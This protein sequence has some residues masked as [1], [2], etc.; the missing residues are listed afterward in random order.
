VYSSIN[1][2][3]VREPRMVR[4]AEHVVCMEEMRS[5]CKTMVGNPKGKIPFGILRC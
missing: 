3:R 5:A 1:I 4:W 2:V